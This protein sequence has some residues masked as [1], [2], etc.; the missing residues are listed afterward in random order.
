M[1]RTLPVLTLSV[2]ALTAVVTGLQF[3]VPGLLETLQR[4]PAMLAQGQVWR[5]VTAWLVQA[6]GVPQI[7][8]NFP[9]LLVAGTLCEWLFSWRVWASAYVMGGLVGEIFGLVWQPVGGGNSV[10]ILGLVGVLLVRMT[11]W[12]G[13][14]GV[15]R[16]ASPVLG[17]LIGAW[18]IVMRDIHGPALLAGYA[19]GLV[20]VRP[21]WFWG[22]A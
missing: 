1:R 5:F 21:R 3:V 2:F 6:D 20:A 4:D 10:A 16:F 7:L 15:Q 17:L 19:V 18:L 8:V 9:A 14:N 11:V 22:R 12:Q 13:H